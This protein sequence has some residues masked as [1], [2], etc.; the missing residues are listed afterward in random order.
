MGWKS[1]KEAYGIEHIVKLE[2]DRLLI[3]S[4]YVGDLIT[5]HP[6]ASITLSS[7]ARGHDGEIGRIRNE[8]ES[9]PDRLR[10]LLAAKDSFQESLPVWTYEDGEIIELRCE[11]YGW[12]NVTHDGRLMY[13]NTFFEKREHA[14]RA[15]ITNGEYAVKGW[16]ENV[17]HAESELTEK[18][19]H[20][21]RAR[22]N[23]ENYRTQA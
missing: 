14:V 7:I 19:E 6:D 5:V 3:G 21:E 10:R 12:P 4:G 9:D 2:G 15:A 18:R 17:E 20:L 11:E 1:V 23:L 8:L 22:R 13:E 16:I